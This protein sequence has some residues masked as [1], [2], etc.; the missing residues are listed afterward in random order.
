MPRKARERSCDASYHIMCRSVTEF[1]LFRD[2]A[3]KDYYLHL[4]KRFLDKFL[5]SLYGYC[6]MDN[7]LHL[8]INPN[9]YDISKFMQC[10]NTAYVR[11]YNYKYSRCGV[12]FQDRFESRILDSSEY[13]L[14]V[15]AYLHNNPHD[16]EGYSGKEENYK[17]SSYG[18]YLGIRKNIPGLVDISF[19]MGI[20]NTTDARNF[21]KKYCEFVSHHRD[22]GNLNKL[23]EKLSTAVVHQYVSGRNS[24]IRDFI[25]AKVMSYIADKLTVSKPDSHAVKSRKKLMNYRS[26]TAYILRVLCG[27]GYKEICN[28]MYNITI[29]GCSK[30]CDRGYELIEKN[31]VFLELFTNLKSCRI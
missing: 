17:Y 28:N 27:L 18:I 9:G 2:D 29:S 10:L 5:C 22:T 31:S 19:M 11:Y 8:H 30:L 21:A 16:I 14:N 24:L 1:L 26:F 12:V 15:S 25:P 4:L 23:K 13:H 6:L 20:F 3:D 7:H